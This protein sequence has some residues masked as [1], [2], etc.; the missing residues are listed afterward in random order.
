MK[1]LIILLSCATLLSA[2]GPSK[3]EILQQQLLAQQRAEAARLEA[4]QAAERAQER[5]SQ[6]RW[7]LQ[8]AEQNTATPQ[9]LLSVL[10]N[11]NPNQTY[12]FDLNLQ[13]E[14]YHYA[15]QQQRFAIIGLR[16]LHPHEQSALELILAR[17]TEL[18][19]L[20]QQVEIPAAERVSAL[21]DN[22]KQAGKLISRQPNWQWHTGA[23]QDFE[24]HTS[25]EVAWEL[26]S[27]QKVK[28]QV[29]LRFCQQTPCAKHYQHQQHPTTGFYGELLSVLIYQEEDNKI[30]AEFISDRP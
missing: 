15:N 21:I 10:N 12:Y 18:N 20:H 26:T 27:Q 17:S 29:G 13:P 16:P 4:L 11:A 1:A 9:K 3:Q 23:F 5:L 14:K 19:N 7:R 2:C 30:L 28:M 25:P 24:W 6:A 8:Q 22:I